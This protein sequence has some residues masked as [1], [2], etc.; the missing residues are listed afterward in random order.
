MA[1]KTKSQ[2]EAAA[3]KARKKTD[4]AAKFVPGGSAIKRRKEEMAR[5]LK[6]I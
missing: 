3:A 6:N 1:K 5:R 2:L 4:K